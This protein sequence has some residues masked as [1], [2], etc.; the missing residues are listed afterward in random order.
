MATLAFFPLDPPKGPTP[1]QDGSRPAK[2]THHPLSAQ[3]GRVPRASPPRTTTKPQVNP[4]PSTRPALDAP[5]GSAD[6]RVIRPCPDRDESAT[7]RIRKAAP[8]WVRNALRPTGGV[9]ECDLRLPH[10]GATHPCRGGGAPG[11]PRGDPRRSRQARDGRGRPEAG[12]DGPG[13]AWAARG[14]RGSRERPGG[15]AESVPGLSRRQPWT[16]GNAKRPGDQC[17]CWSPGRFPSVAGQGFEPWKAKP[18]DLQSAP[19]GRSGNLP[20]LRRRVRRGASPRI[21]D[22]PPEPEIGCSGAP[23][24]GASGARP[25]R[26]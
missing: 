8:R 4:H 5:E 21:A 1:D 7:G 2:R 26:G 12:A 24:P 25:A 6:I 9:G 16:T 11:P 19:I 20:G 17:S 14:G 13:R 3:L 22:D 10:C 23:R 15:R 18:T